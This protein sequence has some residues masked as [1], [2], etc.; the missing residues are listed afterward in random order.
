MFE[1]TF[2]DEDALFLERNSRNFEARVRGINSNAESLCD[3][4]C[5]HTNRLTSTSTLKEVYYPKYTSPE[6]YNACKKATIDGSAKAGYGGLFSLTFTSLEASERFYDRL[7]CAK[8]P[9]LGTNF[10]LAC[11][12]TVLAHWTELE[13][14]EK[15]GVEENLV[16]VAVGLEDIDV[17]K[18]WFGEALKA[19][20]EL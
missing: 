15:W 19:A 20:S 9:S 11:P 17:L 12:Y 10:T 8:G 14:A 16:R 4:L 5:Q 6:N 18:D 7:Q 1:D 13:W 2:F 3:F